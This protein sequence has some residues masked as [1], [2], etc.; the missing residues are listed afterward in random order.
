MVD[1]QMPIDRGQGVAGERGVDNA[2]LAEQ[3]AS[4]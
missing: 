3:S 1:D 2:V 4:L